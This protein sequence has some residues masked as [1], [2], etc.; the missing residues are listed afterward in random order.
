MLKWL[1]GDNF[2][3][4]RSWDLKFGE[5]FVQNTVVLFVWKFFWKN[6]DLFHEHQNRL[7]H[8]L[9]WCEISEYEKIL[10]LWKTC[11][12]Y[13][14]V[15]ANSPRRHTLTFF[16][17]LGPLDDRSKCRF[18]HYTNDETYMKEWWI[19]IEVYMSHC[20]RLWKVSKLTWKKIQ[21]YLFWDG[22]RAHTKHISW[23]KSAPGRNWT[24]KLTG[25][26]FQKFCYA[27]KNFWKLYFWILCIL[28][29]LLPNF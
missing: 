4:K 21:K 16:V 11:F 26:I 17:V 18:Y 10:F 24:S 27:A 15:P 14:K 19:L 9:N 5:V 29:S 2:S 12:N 8:R 6:D 3:T 28:K 20:Q 22:T 1:L 13:L 23:K 7:A 25:K